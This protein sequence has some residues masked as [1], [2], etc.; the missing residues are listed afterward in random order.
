MIRRL[1]RLPLLLL[2]AGLVVMGIHD[3]TYR[4]VG[5]TDFVLGGLISH[6]GTDILITTA[7]LAGVGL[8]WEIPLRGL[9]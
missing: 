6:A 5:G 1:L 7:I 8:L 3:F 9:R 2:V 4:S